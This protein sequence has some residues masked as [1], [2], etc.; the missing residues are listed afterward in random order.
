MA[1]TFCEMGGGVLPQLKTT[2]TIQIGLEAISMS[3]LR[4]E[5][6][7]GG[8]ENGNSF[9]WIGD[10]TVVDGNNWAVGFPVSGEA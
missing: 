9:I 7:L 5:Y 4:G 3:T 1:K 10:D 8:K 6:W 2:S